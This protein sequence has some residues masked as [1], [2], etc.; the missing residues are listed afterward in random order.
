M[1]SCQPIKRLKDKKKKNWN[2][3]FLVCIT[4]FPPYCIIICISIMTIITNNITTMTCLDLCRLFQVIPNIRRCFWL[5]SARSMVMF[6][7]YPSFNAV[8][9]F[10]SVKFLVIMF[11]II[12]II[13]WLL[14]YC[15]YAP[16]WCCMVMWCTVNK[17]STQT[18][19]TLSPKTL[20]SH[21]TTP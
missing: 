8:G 16:V 9:V 17:T 19:P 5:G 7:L 11:L 20:S 10:F 12:A 13:I 18:T 21:H 15:T 14:G 3:R 1:E 6:F 2:V 4:F